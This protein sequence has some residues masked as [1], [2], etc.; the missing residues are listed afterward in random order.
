MSDLQSF[1]SS[2]NFLVDLIN[3]VLKCMYFNRLILMVFSFPFSTQW[4]HFVYTLLMQIL[5]DF[6]SVT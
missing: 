2:S 1:L 5:L 6:A 3:V 4:G